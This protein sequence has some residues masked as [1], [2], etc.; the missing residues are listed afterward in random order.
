MAL[1][2]NG[3]LAIDE[4]DVAVKPIVSSNDAPSILQNIL[5][6]PNLTQD[7]IQVLGATAGHSILLTS[8]DKSYQQIIPVSGDTISIDLSHLPAGMYL[9][10]LTDTRNGSTKVE[11]VIKY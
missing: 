9:V 6:S 11:K 2:A 5:V 8:M 3:G 1:D 4:F 10:L 7:F